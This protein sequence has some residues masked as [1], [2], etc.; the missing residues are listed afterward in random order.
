MRVAEKEIQ[1]PQLPSKLEVSPPDRPETAV[2]RRSEAELTIIPPAKHRHKLRFVLI[3]VL[4]AAAVG[5]ILVR[6]FFRAA[7]PLFETAKVERGA[8]QAFVTATGNLNP[9]V[10]VQVGSQV[11]GNITALYAD[12]NTKVHKGQLIAQID[13]ALFQA[14]VDAA[15]GAVKEHRASV[16]SVSAQYLKAAADLSVARANKASLVALE[17]KDRASFT[18]L[19]EQWTRSERLFE[20]GIIS[21]R[22]HDSAYA[23]FQSAEAQLAAD[24]AQ[25]SAAERNIQSA[26]AQLAA[27]KAQL[28]AAEAQLNQAQASLNQ[29]LLNLDHTRIVAPV[30]GTVIARHFDVGQTV[31][32]SFQAPDIFDIGEDLTKMQVDTNVDEADVGTV[33]TGQLATFL[34]DAYPGTTFRGIV[35][36]V[37]RAPINAQNVVTY[38]VVITADNPDSKLFP[39]MTAKVTILTSREDQALKVPNAALRFRP[40]AQIA[41]RIKSPPKSA[42][43]S[44]VYILSDSEI[45]AVPVVTGITDGRATEV[46]SGDVKEGDTVILRMAAPNTS[47][48]SPSSLPLR[49]LPGT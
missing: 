6:Q 5:G 43:V 40:P 26:E 44:Q 36:D 10:N 41:A 24:R 20:S 11:S 42:D 27:A 22:D 30:S 35:A 38:D 45:R 48:T 1:K 34:I 8:I 39:G 2:S 14:Q 17:A 21:P 29:A 33:R 31:A 37:R 23:A 7:P 4:V 12:F 9:V 13:P 15:T 28:S 49:R 18:N 47:A 3:G 16:A 19:R 25:I 46:S 32:A